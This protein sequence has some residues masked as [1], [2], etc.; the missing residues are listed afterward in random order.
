[1]PSRAAAKYVIPRAQ[2]ALAKWVA[3][4][5]SVERYDPYGV[6]EYAGIR[7]DGAFVF[8]DAIPDHELR[9]Q[10]ERATAVLEYRAAERAAAQDEE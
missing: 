5:H 3:A 6:P 4:Q 2:R 8:N 9:L 1:M 7:V 10:I